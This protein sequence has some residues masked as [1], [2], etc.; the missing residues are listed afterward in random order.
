MSRV[1]SIQQ[2]FWCEVSGFHDSRLDKES[3]QRL[4]EVFI[5]AKVIMRH[6]RWSQKERSASTCFVQILSLTHWNQTIFLPMYYK[7]RALNL[8]HFG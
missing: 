5:E 7:S 2:L 8:R 1:Q 6:I 3:L 4:D